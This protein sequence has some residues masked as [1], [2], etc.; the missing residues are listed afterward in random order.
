MISTFGGAY[1]DRL[2]WLVFIPIHLCSHSDRKLISKTS[3]EI[4]RVQ[5][6]HSFGLKKYRN[7]QRQSTTI[8][9]DV[10]VTY[11]SRS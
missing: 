6:K 3:L 5:K 10:H 9:H 7:N 1:L 2:F 4:S 8:T 11:G